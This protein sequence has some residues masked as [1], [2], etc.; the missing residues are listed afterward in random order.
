MEV[1]RVSGPSPSLGQDFARIVEDDPLPVVGPGSGR[2]N[3]ARI[4]CLQNE[5]RAADELPR[6]QF[7][8]RPKRLDRRERMPGNTRTSRSVTCIE[9]REARVVSGVDQFVRWAQ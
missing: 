4:T 7:A 6:L 2:V 3:A 1:M 8:S 5:I 9:W